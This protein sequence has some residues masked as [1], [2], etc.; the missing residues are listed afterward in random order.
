MTNR[1]NSTDD[2]DNT[3]H[4]NDKK[5]EL[6]KKIKG[7]TNE[8]L[9]GT[10]KELREVLQHGTKSAE[11]KMREL[12]QSVDEKQAD[13]EEQIAA[14]NI[15][16]MQTLSKHP[17]TDE[18][19]GSFEGKYPNSLFNKSVVTEDK[20]LIG[21]I[22]K[23][24]EDLI[25]VFSDRENLRYDI[26]KSKV[27]L[28]GGLT[29]VNKEEYSK[30]KMDRDA[31]LPEGKSPRD[32]EEKILRISHESRS[33]EGIHGQVGNV[34]YNQQTTRADA[35]INEGEQLAKNPRF[36]TTHVSTPQNYVE[37]ES[38]ILRK[39]KRAAIELKEIIFAGARVAEKKVKEIQ[40]TAEEKRAEADAEKISKMG[41]LAMQFTD[42]FEN[43]LS[44]IRTRTFTEQE[45]IYT[46]FL[47][48]IDQQRQ[49]IIARRDMSIRLKDSV[50]R[51][52]VGVEDM[53]QLP[54]NFESE[55]PETH[56]RPQLNEKQTSSKDRSPEE[57]RL[58]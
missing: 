31:P 32:S 51:P 29:I 7:T 55:L 4:D 44:E 6:V 8:K 19:L 16:K 47:K 20:I 57:N 40:H 38:E 56:S 27:I 15:S 42:S 49:L 14:E 23:E 10:A 48:L 34:D 22:A 52:V 26:P 25:V 3:E 12:Q 58:G 54:R 9:R 41:D 17:T 37:D 21:R 24:T 18:D 53:Q 1:E 2:I 45:Q 5:T 28:D 33:A 30:F 13:S 43:V 46:G 50:P 11:K 36:T 35:L 39:V